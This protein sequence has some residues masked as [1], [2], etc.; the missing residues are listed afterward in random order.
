MELQKNKRRAIRRK[1][2]IIAKEMKMNKAQHEKRIE[3]KRTR[4][5][6]TV[7]NVEDYMAEEFIHR[8]AYLQAL[9][10]SQSTSR[11]RDRSDEPTNPRDEDQEGL[12]PGPRIGDTDSRDA[13]CDMVY[14]VGGSSCSGGSE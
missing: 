11:D 3:P 14:D 9:Y 8:P 12:L 5:K 13:S 7:R 6:V 1:R 4:E 10:G 2:N